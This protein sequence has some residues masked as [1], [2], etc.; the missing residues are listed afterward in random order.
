[1]GLMLHH[2]FAEGEAFH[3]NWINNI[4]LAYV[5]FAREN[6]CHIKWI[7]VGLAIHAVAPFAGVQFLRALHLV[8]DH[9][10]MHGSSLQELV[11]GAIVYAI[12]QVM[13]VGREIEEDRSQ[14]V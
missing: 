14:F 5:V 11:L 13:Q 10:W 8:I 9:Q 7:G 3:M 1:M 2:H 12:A 4:G 6:A